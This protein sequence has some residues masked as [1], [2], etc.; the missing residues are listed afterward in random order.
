MRG[1]AGDRRSRPATAPVSRSRDT[2]G[3]RRSPRNRRTRSPARPRPPAAPSR[4]PRTAR[5]RA[6][7]DPDLRVP[8]TDSG[9]SP[10]C[11]GQPPGPAARVPADHC[12][13]RGPFPYPDG[14]RERKRSEV[15]GARVRGGCRRDRG[16]LLLGGRPDRGRGPR[17]G[18]AHDR[19]RHRRGRGP[20]G[21]GPSRRLGRD[22]PAAR[23][24]DAEVDRELRR[25]PQV[26]DDAA[27]PAARAL[28][29]AHERRRDGERVGLRVPDRRRCPPGRRRL[30]RRR[31]GRLRPRAGHPGRT[32]GRRCRPRGVRSR[33]GGAV[34]SR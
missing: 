16:R 5:R 15:R 7:R 1:A 30:P 8:C 24:H 27:P 33:A 12:G 21:R 2:R 18:K 13:C 34:R 26:A 9:A 31:R 22:R 11:D 4:T 10:P 17:V 20:E 29:R 32:A 23:V 6:T 25:G 19:H 14:A 28:S 3:T